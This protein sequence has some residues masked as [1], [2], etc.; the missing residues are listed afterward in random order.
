MRFLVKGTEAIERFEI[1][2]GCEHFTSVGSCGTLGVGKTVEHEGEKVRLC[3]C[4]MKAK[5]KLRT[6]SCPI[7]KWGKRL[8]AE[9]VQEL[10]KLLK[11]ENGRIDGKAFRK[12][13]YTFNKEFGTRYE[14]TTCGSCVG[15]AIRQMEETLKEYEDTTS[16][17]L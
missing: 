12:L 10:R 8:D 4:F 14:F 7:G 9:T 13:I 5:T 16:S 1:C 17:D 3:G 2:K 11:V 15:D 6:S